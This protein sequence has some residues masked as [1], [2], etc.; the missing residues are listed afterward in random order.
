MKEIKKEEVEILLIKK[1]IKNTSKGLVD[2]NGNPI[3]FYRTRNK[4]YIEDKYVNI[5]KKLI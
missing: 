2:K 1:Y 4:R 5:A 3:G